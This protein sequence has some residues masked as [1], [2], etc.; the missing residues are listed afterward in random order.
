[1]TKYLVDG[2]R[3]GLHSGIK[4][5]H[6]ILTGDVVAPIPEVSLQQRKALTIYNKSGSTIWVGDSTVTGTNSRYP[7]DNN[8]EWGLDIS[9][10][11]VLY[12]YSPTT[13]SGIYVFEIA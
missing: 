2:I 11:L 8:S 7:I 13:V 9:D 6:I 4:A 10:R 12:A 5:T 3:H 1:M